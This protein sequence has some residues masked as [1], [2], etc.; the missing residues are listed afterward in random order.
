MPGT[1]KQ[2]QEVNRMKGLAIESS[3]SQL[4]E[5]VSYSRLLNTSQQ[6]ETVSNSNQQKKW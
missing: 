5:T 1:S 3:T 2:L 4:K 6:K